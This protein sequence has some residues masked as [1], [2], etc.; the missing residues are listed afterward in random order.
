MTCRTD[1]STA[2]LP[3]IESEMAADYLGQAER[4]LGNGTTAQFSHVPAVVL[5]GAVLEKGL[6]SLCEQLTP[7]EATTGAEGQ[8]LTM[9][10]LIDALKRRAVFNEITAKQLR[11]WAAIRNSAAHGHLDEFTKE[12]AL[13][14]VSGV[15][16]FLGRYL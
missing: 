16:D 13:S 10:P 2:S 14:M 11:A 5:A 1:F 4:L 7:P 9:A 15:S 3:R 12:Q 8:P 6:R